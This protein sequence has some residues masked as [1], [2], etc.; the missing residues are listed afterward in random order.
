M[1]PTHLQTKDALHRLSEE[2]RVVHTEKR[3]LEAQLMLA[4]NNMLKAEELLNNKERWVLCA[5]AP[6]GG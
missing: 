5:W 3:R 1:T 4:R 6:G 2:H